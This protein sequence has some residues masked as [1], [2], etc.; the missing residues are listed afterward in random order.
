MVCYGD[1][2]SNVNIDNND[3]YGN[4]MIVVIS[5]FPIT[6]PFELME[7]D[8]KNNVISFEEKPVLREVMNIVLLYPKKT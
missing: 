1:T 8:E 2:L 6:I 3:F 4:I 7:I 5:S